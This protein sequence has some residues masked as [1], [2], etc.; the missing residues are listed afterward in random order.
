MGL[1]REVEDEMK[2]LRHGVIHNEKNMTRPS[3]A[4]VE[5]EHEK[6]KS[7][8]PHRPRTPSNFYTTEERIRDLVLLDAMRLLFRR[9]FWVAQSLKA[10]GDARGGALC[11]SKCWSDGRRCFVITVLGVLLYLLATFIHLGKI[12]SEIREAGFVLLGIADTPFTPF[13]SYNNRNLQI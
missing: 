3:E 13:L 4:I 1:G 11:E 5:M 9:N 8:P 10:E 12:L 6:E 2:G 7:D